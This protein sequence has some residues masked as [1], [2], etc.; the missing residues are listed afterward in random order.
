MCLFLFGEL[1]LACIE[2]VFLLG[3]RSLTPV[4][5]VALRFKYLAIVFDLGQMFR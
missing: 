4:E 3:Q 1:A 2:P 5:G